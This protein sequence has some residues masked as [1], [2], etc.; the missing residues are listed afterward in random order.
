MDAHKKTGNKCLP[1]LALSLCLCWSFCHF[2]NDALSI[3]VV[4]IRAY[5]M[6][7][8]WLMTLWTNRKSRSC[9]LHIRWS[10]LVPSGLGRFPFWNCHCLHLLLLKVISKKQFFS[11]TSKVYTLKWLMSTVFL[12]YVNGFSYVWYDTCGTC[13]FYMFFHFFRCIFISSF[14]YVIPS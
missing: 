1:Y 12:Y 3:V 6:W 11:S 5:S 9:H 8:L 2:I 10:S 14:L 13:I 4:A 7:K